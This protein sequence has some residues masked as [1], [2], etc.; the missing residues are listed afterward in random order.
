MSLK[1]ATA[2]KHK[3]AERKLFNIKMFKGELTKAEYLLYLLQQYQVFSAIEAIGVPHLSLARAEKVKEDMQEII[4]E[5][6]NENR[7]LPSTIKYVEYLSKFDKNTILPHVYLNYLAVMFGGQM[8]KSKVPSKGK[9]YDFENMQEAM[10]SIRQ[11]Q[12]DEWAEEVNI[13]YD[14]AIAMFDDLELAITTNQ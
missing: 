13:G 6:I 7:V 9:M 4:S 14:F 2:E 11:V 3:I 8:M 1:E 10:M 5:N 12:K